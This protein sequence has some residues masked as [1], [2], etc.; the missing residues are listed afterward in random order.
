MSLIWRRKGERG[1]KG[2]EQMGNENAVEEE[3]SE[4]RNVKED[5][6]MSEKRKM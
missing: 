1:V 2:E 5:S 4:G 6:R 3:W